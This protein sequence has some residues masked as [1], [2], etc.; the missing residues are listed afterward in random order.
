M[1]RLHAGD[2]GISKVIEGTTAANGTVVAGSAVGSSSIVGTAGDGSNAPDLRLGRPSILRQR[3]AKT[4]HT[5]P[6]LIFGQWESSF[7]RCSPL[8]SP[9]RPQTLQH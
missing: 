4:N 6:R 7:T 9:L 8:C 3:F 1:T 2:F 5:I